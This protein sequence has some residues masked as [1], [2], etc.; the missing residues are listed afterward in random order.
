M[1]ISETTGYWLRVQFPEAPLVYPEGEQASQ[2]YPWKLGWGNREC[3]VLWDS[4]I[5]VIFFFPAPHSCQ[6]CSSPFYLVTLSIPFSSSEAFLEF[7][8]QVRPSPIPGLT[9]HSSMALRTAANFY[10]LD[11]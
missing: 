5:P 7:P 9:A 3:F 10:L 2:A 6:P 1:E 8:D 4:E 11:D